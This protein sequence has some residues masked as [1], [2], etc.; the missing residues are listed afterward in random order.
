MKTV[1]SHEASRIEF[2]HTRRIPSSKAVQQEGTRKGHR[3][4]LYEIYRF[5][6]GDADYF[7]ENRMHALLSGQLFVI[8]SDEFHNLSVRSDAFYEKVAVRFPRELAQ[9]LSV[10]GTDLL[11]CF[12]NRP[13]GVDNKVI[14]DAETGARIGDAL[15][16]MQGLF[17]EDSESGYALRVACLH[18]LLVYM[19]IA[20]QM[21]NR[22]PGA[23]VMA[24]SRLSPVLEYID[25]NLEKDLT[26]K[27]VSQMFFISVSSLCA[28]FRETTGV[29]M[30]EY[31]T[32][33]RVSRAREM[34]AAGARVGEA[35]AACGFNDYANFIR[36]FGKVV[37]VSPGKYGRQK[38]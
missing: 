14:P 32:L 21:T 7:I 15:T 12:D 31:V 27:T 5:H 2:V 4:E 29:G 22:E 37:G 8:R 30:H 17:A 26:L 23:R 9:S 20:H 10:Y 19:N 11:A 35:C 1:W 33:R 24:T 38:V 34:L 13:R 6:S 25:A 28:M 16:R 3:H 36:T 18:E